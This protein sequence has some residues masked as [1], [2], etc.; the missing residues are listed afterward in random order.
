MATD[1]IGDRGGRGVRLDLSPFTID[2]ERC[3]RSRPGEG[4]ETASL[5]LHARTGRPIITYP[6]STGNQMD[7]ARPS[8]DVSARGR[9]SANQQR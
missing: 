8:G 7:D 4:F 5:E 2:K 9:I 6:M 1:G 3:R